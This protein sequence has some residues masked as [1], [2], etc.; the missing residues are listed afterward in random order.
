VASRE[1]IDRSTL[2]RR[3]LLCLYGLGTN[4]GLKRICAGIEREY[5]LAIRQKLFHKEHLRNAITQVVNEIFR[6]R[7]LHIWGEGTTACVRLKKFGSW[8]Q[9]LMTEAYSLRWS[10]SHD[11]LARREE[12]A[13]IYSQLK[14]AHPVKWQP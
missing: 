7:M 14:P 4:T 12:S 11:L 3:L 10:G 2:Q 1:T 5:H 8:D 9:N 6:T 13:C